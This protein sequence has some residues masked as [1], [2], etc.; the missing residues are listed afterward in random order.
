MA[1]GA[2][3]GAGGSQTPL[4]LHTPVTAMPRGQGSACALGTGSNQGSAGEA[5]GSCCPQRGFPVVGTA[6]SLPG[7]AHPLPPWTGRGGAAATPVKGR[8][9]APPAPSTP[10]KSL[11]LHLL[12]ATAP[13]LCR[14]PSASAGPKESSLLPR[15]PSSFASP[16]EQVWGGMCTAPQQSTFRG[17]RRKRRRISS[18]RAQPSASH[19]ILARDSQQLMSGVKGAQRMTRA[20]S[21]LPPT[22]ASSSWLP[23][24]TGMNSARRKRGRDR[25]AAGKLHPILQPASSQGLSMPEMGAR[26]LY[27]CSGWGTL[28]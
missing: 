15:L 4:P 19:I 26:C 5:S 25:D 14:A 24:T 9:I 22:S 12:D 18:S 6:L 27:P 7:L 10:A 2:A 3:R 20:Q 28:Y 16:E 13:A 23:P 11:F 1:A 21:S 8:S 17:R